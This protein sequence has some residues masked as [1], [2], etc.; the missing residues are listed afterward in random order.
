MYACKKNSTKPFNQETNNC[1]Q[2]SAKVLK[3]LYAIHKENQKSEPER[4]V[5]EVED[6]IENLN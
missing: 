4:E 5:E 3:I 6:T 1:M 2:W